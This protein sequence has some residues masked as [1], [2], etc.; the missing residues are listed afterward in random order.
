MHRSPKRNQMIELA[1]PMA[2]R[3]HSSSSTME[4]TVGLDFFLQPLLL[5]GLA[6]FITTQLR[7]EMQGGAFPEILCLLGNS[8]FVIPQSL[9]PAK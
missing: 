1:R 5:R 7:M 2:S 3:T 6:F 4:I 8:C 9:S